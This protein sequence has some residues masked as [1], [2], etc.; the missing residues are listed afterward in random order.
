VLSEDFISLK[1][2]GG[3]I[4]NLFWFSTAR[5]NRGFEGQRDSRQLEARQKVK[6]PCLVQASTD[7]GF[8]SALYITA[9]QPSVF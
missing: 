6:E 2:D 9:D 5:L 1:Q 7:V 3:G 8:N 4:V